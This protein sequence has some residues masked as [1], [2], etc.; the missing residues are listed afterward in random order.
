MSSNKELV[1]DFYLRWILPHQVVLDFST[2]FEVV[3][4]I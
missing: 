3:L 1:G 4:E 2:V